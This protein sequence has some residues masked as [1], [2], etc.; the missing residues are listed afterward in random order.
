MNFYSNVVRVVHCA[1]VVSHTGISLRLEN[2]YWDV[3]ERSD[4]CTV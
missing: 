4:T 2:D 1:L 3:L